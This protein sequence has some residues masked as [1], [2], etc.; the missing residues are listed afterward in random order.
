VKLS[1]RRAFCGKEKAE[2]YPSWQAKI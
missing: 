1:G 2:T